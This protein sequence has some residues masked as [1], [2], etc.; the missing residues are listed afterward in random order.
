MDDGQN[1]DEVYD[2]ANFPS[3]TFA[4]FGVLVLTSASLCYSSVGFYAHYVLRVESVG[5]VER[6]A[7]AS[8]VM[9]VW[10][11]IA[12]LLYASHPFW[13]MRRYG[14]CIQDLRHIGLSDNPGLSK[15]ADQALAEIDAICQ[16]ASI[17]TPKVYVNL[18]ISD[19]SAVVFGTG[20]RKILIVG[21]G[22]LFLRV[23]QP[24][25]FRAIMF[26]EVGHIYFKDVWVVFFARALIISAFILCG[27]ALFY[28]IGIYLRDYV[29]YVM[30]WSEKYGFGDVLRITH[31]YWSRQGEF[32][33]YLIY[34]FGL[35]FLTATVAILSYKS[36]LRKRELYADI[37]SSTENSKLSIL[38]CF[39]SEGGDGGWSLFR[40]HPLPEKRVEVVMRPEGVSGPSASS[41]IFM[42]ISISWMAEL[43]MN[44]TPDRDFSGLGDF[45][46]DDHVHVMFDPDF[47][48][49]AV[50]FVMMLLIVLRMMFSIAVYLCVGCA[51][52]FS[53][54]KYLGRVMLLLV[55]GLEVSS[56]FSPNRIL[57]PLYYESISEWVLDYSFA[58][59][60]LIIVMIISIIFFYVSIC[61]VSRVDYRSKPSGLRW[62]L[63]LLLGVFAANGLMNFGFLF[64]SISLGFIDGDRV[65]YYEYVLTYIFPYFVL[66]P[67]VSFL[68]AI[69][70]DFPFRF[71]W[72]SWNVAGWARMRRKD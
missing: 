19:S 60:V 38:R 40:S 12:G 22:M 43:F 44:D 11:L 35:L 15:V 20:R 33:D 63:I 69:F 7:V 31:F 62:V 58:N 9:F 27:A 5:A 16:R 67:I 64:A 53:A 45:F 6:M 65:E 28:W 56:Y 25:K 23:S 32:L 36:L 26:H 14:R 55:G 1:A 70:W 29:E 46:N 42:C 18:D 24:E 50:F 59:W 57:P 49:A 3:S 4:E 61:V 68:L 39:S 48:F 51:S 47:V 30:K 13:R 52:G 71:Y 10:L 8:Q 37:F 17:L 66:I 54:L 34:R 21:L 41:I 72:F 2:V